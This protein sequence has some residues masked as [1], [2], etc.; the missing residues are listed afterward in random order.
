MYRKGK[1]L[2]TRKIIP[3]AVALLMALA[4][5]AC[6]PLAE[7][8]RFTVRVDQRMEL[9]AVVQALSSY[10][11]PLPMLFNGFDFEYK[12]AFREHFEPF[13]GYRA[14]ALFD[15]MWPEGFSFDA[16]VGAVLH[17]GEPPELEPIIPIPEYYQRRAGGAERLDEFIEELR[18]FA[19]DADFA[20]FHLANAKY[21]RRLENAVKAQIGE[22]NPG[23]LEDYYGTRQNSF[24]IVLVPLFHQGAFGPSVTYEDGSCDVYSVIG[25]T[26]LRDGELFFLG[27]DDLKHLIWHEFSHSFVNPVVDNFTQ[28][29]AEYAALLKPIKQQMADQAYQDWQTVVYEHVVRAVVA[30][31]ALEHFGKD[32]YSNTIAQEVARGFIY[33]EPICEALAFDYEPNRDIYPDLKSFFPRILEVFRGEL[34]KR[35]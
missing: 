8:A 5:S 23:V 34:R 16:P 35:R 6:T 33:I 30:R 21:Y 18:N 17:Y 31:L 3:L 4:L 14:V 7:E 12:T 26:E 2:K 9:L 32:A 1:Q 20:Q 19:R 24:N 29:V 25:P 10:P 27:P 28:Q 13:A 11:G 15:E 22:I